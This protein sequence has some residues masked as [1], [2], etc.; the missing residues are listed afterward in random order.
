MFETATGRTL[1]PP[2]GIKSFDGVKVAF[3]GMTLQGTPAIVTPT[4]VAGLEFRDEAD[5]VNA[6]LPR[7]RALGVAAVVVLVHQGGFQAGGGVGDINGCD[8][9]LKNR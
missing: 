7:L 6:L 1:L 2:Y 9:D 4:G 8:G 5:T 3:I